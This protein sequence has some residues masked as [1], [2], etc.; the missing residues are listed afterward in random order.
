MNTTTS[1]DAAALEKQSKITYEILSEN[2]LLFIDTLIA[3]RL[4]LP[5][6]KRTAELLY[7][8][9]TRMTMVVSYLNIHSH[10]TPLEFAEQVA[11]TF[12]I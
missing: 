1:G 2:T 7:N 5:L 4:P 6:V 3:A 10:P 9:N 12:K 8:N 11:N